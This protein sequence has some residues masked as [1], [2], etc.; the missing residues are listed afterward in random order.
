MTEMEQEDQTIFSST[1]PLF[2]VQQPQRVN[3]EEVPPKKSKKLIMIGII[4]ALFFVIILVLLVLVSTKP[5]LTLK[6]GLEASPTVS[7]D[8]VSDPVF[9]RLNQLKQDLDHADPT[10]RNLPFPPVNMEIGFE[11]KY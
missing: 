5:K 3:P 2:D 9:D 10:N 6:D 8:L 4:L 11:K 1:Q 7:T